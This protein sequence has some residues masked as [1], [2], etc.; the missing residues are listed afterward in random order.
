MYVAF[1]IRTKKHI[2]LNIWKYFLKENILTGADSV[3]AYNKYACS[4]PG[5]FKGYI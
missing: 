4:K 3:I 1:R 2:F 5:Q